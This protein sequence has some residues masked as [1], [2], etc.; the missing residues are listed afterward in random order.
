MKIECPKSAK[1]NIFDTLEIFPDAA[2]NMGSYLIFAIS[3]TFPIFL[4]W[5]KVFLAV[6]P[7]LSMLE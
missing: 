3:D 7:R 5:R 1:L 4:R 2:L 6:N